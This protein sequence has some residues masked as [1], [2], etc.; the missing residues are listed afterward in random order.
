MARKVAVRVPVPLGLKNR[1]AVQE[2]PTANAKGQLVVKEK[3]P[4]FA[5]V[6]A[7]LTKFRVTVPVFVTV[8]TCAVL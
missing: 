8:K 5:P 4:G 1:L 7:P 6:N 3:S 2:A